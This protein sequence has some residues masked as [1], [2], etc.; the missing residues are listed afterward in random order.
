MK[1]IFAAVIAFVLF[2]S[3]LAVGAEASD[4]IGGYT[5][6][7][8]KDCSETDKYAAEVMAKYVKAITGKDAVILDD[9]AADN[10]AE[11]VIGDT[12]RKAVD[13]SGL[14]DGGYRIVS[15]GDSLYING[16]GTRGCIYGVYGFLEKYCGC[17][18]YTS[19][20][21]NIPE[22]EKI[23]LGGI[24][25]TY[26]PYFEYAETDWRSPHDLEYSVAHGLNSGVYRNIPTRMGGDVDYISGFA[27]TL[28][29]RFCSSQKYFDE[30]PEYFA[31][32][33]GKRTPNQLCLTNPDVIRIVTEEV[34]ELIAS[35]YDPSQSLQIV[36][37]TQHDNQD[38]CTCKNCKA[39][40][41]EN[42]SQS[43]TMITFANTVARA[44]KAAGYDNIAIDTFAYQYTRQAPLKVKPDDNVIVRLCSI[45][46][47]FAHPLEDET[48]T[49][50]RDFMKDLEN[51]NKICDR[52][53]IWDY[54]TNFSES[55][56]IFPNFGVLQQNVQTFYEHGVKGVYEEG[57]YY[58]DECDGE[59]GELKAYLLSKLMQDPYM[60]YY[61]AMDDFLQ[62]YYGG[63]WRNIR[64]FIDMT[65]AKSSA[66]KSDH[67]D[68]RKRG[69]ATLSAF[70]ISDVKRSDALW[71]DAA[72]QAELPE[73]KA[74]VKR[75]ELCW[76]YWKCVNRRSEFSLFG[77]SLYKR[78]NERDK[79]YKDM[80]KLGITK[81]G[82]NEY[83]YLSDCDALHLIRP[84][85]KW[86][87][88]Y[89]EKIWDLLSP[90]IVGFFNLMKSID[91]T[92]N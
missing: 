3:P 58:I 50:N 70:R 76:R 74:N 47:C 1:K 89:D 86:T 84:C 32:R 42:G 54:V 72:A 30:H 13:V 79:L 5:V 67:L 33:N 63:G 85:R 68:I 6:I 56:C 15:D 10:G 61:D 19:K 18:W 52:I 48:C 83:R 4:S 55:L 75:S 28:T 14:E 41:L 91:I 12:S 92:F 31:L 82:E 34:L 81:I 24:D 17:R 77:N 27:H 23:E 25:Y 38:Y 49:Q 26:D 35:C 69:Y 43:G 36:S 78:M 65:I 16:S 66:G 80:K 46:C 11:I 45:E 44:V 20:L 7:I 37:L 22:L 64:E 51:W 62:A 90:L 88:Q 73:Q 59:F 9:S 71:A 21:K 29:N 60:D 53:Y 40:D 87:V 2:I 57:V 8:A 39:I